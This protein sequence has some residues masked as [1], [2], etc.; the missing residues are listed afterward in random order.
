MGLNA[1]PPDNA[2]LKEQ[3]AAEYPQTVT[4]KLPLTVVAAANNVE[5]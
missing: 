5:G 1:H 3:Q 2:L 4:F